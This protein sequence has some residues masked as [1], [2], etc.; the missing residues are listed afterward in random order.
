MWSQK[1]RCEA[2]LGWTRGACF[3]ARHSSQL[4]LCSEAQVDEFHVLYTLSF[5]HCTSY[6]QV[7]EFQDINGVQ[8]ELLRLLAQ[9]NG[10]LFV[11]LYTLYSLPYNRLFVSATS[12]KPSSL[13]FTPYTRYSVPAYFIPYPFRSATPIKP[14]TAGVG[15][16]CRIRYKVYST[17]YRV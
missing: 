4:G 3:R 14:S 15:R 6:F 9:R 17:K 7:D 1:A 8:Y 12:I 13:D 10:R 11:V 2:L 16:T 5:I